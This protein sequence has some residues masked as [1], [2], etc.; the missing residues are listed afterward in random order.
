MHKRKGSLFFWVLN[1]T[2][3]PLNYNAPD[4]VSTM[5]A[6]DTADLWLGTT[7]VWDGVSVQTASQ[8]ITD[9]KFSF[10]A[11]TATIGIDNI[12]ITAIPEPTAALLGGLG[13]LAL[14]R[15][16]RS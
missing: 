13:L 8:S 12:V 10:S 5:L 7:K 4:S 3:S 1:N 6:N 14:L 9:L 2:G 16:R 15:R 11:G